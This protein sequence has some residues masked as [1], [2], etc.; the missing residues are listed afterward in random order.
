MVITPN[1]LQ[2][3]Y[4]FKK[5][6]QMHFCLQFYMYDCIQVDQ[7]VLNVED[8]YKNWPEDKFGKLNENSIGIVTPY[9]LQVRLIPQYLIFVL[10]HLSLYATI[11]ILVNLFI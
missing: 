8:M 5:L 10:K 6:V 11:L 2:A 9:I 4:Y 7:I 1:K 3:K